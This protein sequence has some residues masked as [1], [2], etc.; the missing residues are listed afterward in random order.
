MLIALHDLNLV[1]RFSDQVVLLSDGWIKS[2]G[3]PRQVLVPPLL[4]D[5]YGIE[6]HV[7]DDPIHGTPLVLTG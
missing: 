7:V 1:A 5:V 3:E 6:I 4:A 2:I